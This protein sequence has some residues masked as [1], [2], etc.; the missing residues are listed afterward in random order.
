MKKDYLSRRESIILSAVDIIDELGIHA[1]SIRELASRQE[2]T[3]P[4][5]YRHFT[6]KLDIIIGIIDYYSHFDEL[7]MNT[8]EVQG[9]NAKDSIRFFC[10]AFME[11]YEN[12]PALTAIYFSYHSL[13]YDPVLFDKISEIDEKRNSFLE[14]LI[15]K[16]QKSGEIVKAFS[17]TELVDMIM[18]LQTQLIF[19]WRMRRYN[20][21]LKKSAITTLEKILEIC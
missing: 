12:Y 3:E 6:N 19:K 18:G 7:I 8:I 1:L 9:L 4:A 21:S 17:G 16:G 11:Y 2:V 14:S 15:E 13:I 10:K 20:F 5:I